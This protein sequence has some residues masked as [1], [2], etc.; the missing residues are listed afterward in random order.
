MRRRRRFAWWIAAAVNIS[1]ASSAPVQTVKVLGHTAGLTYGKFTDPRENAFSVDVPTGWRTSG[2]LFRRA[3]LDTRPSLEVLSPD[4]AVRLSIGDPDVPPFALPN[5]ML[6]MAGFR[7]GSWYSP[8]YG[9]SYLVRRYLP[10]VA[11]ADEYA[12]TKA[13][14]DAV[15]TSVEVSARRARLDVTAALNAVY[16]RFPMYGVEVREEAGEV[17]FRCM[18]EGQPRRG[19]Y[20]VSTLLTHTNGN[21]IWRAERILGFI[22]PEDKVGLAQA[23]LARL[24]ASIRVNP[25]WERMQQGITRA[26]SQIAAATQDQISKIVR[27]TFQYKSAV[28]TE[29]SRQ[30]ANARRGVVDVRDPASGETWK[31]ENTS[32]YYWRRPGSDQVVGTSTHTSPGPGF[33]LLQVY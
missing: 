32:D 13:A 4:G 17:E 30:G 8:G 20:L 10:G 33:E 21:G 7:E 1:L 26:S 31:V 11:F 25:E 2:G 6:A 15:C 18:H 9:L 29:V 22:A 27:Q 12:R 5:Q 28:D 19:Y 16:E 3:P 23:V 24:A 14:R